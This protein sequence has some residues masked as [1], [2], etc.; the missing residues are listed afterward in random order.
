MHVAHKQIKMLSVGFPFTN[1][2]MNALSFLSKSFLC[3][4]KPEK[5]W[6]IIVQPFA[7]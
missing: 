2:E 4:F 6:I 1:S 3:P 5:V 7:I